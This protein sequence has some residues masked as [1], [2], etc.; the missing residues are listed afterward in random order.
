MKKINKYLKEQI[1]KLNKIVKKE[2][3]NVEINEEPFD[4]YLRIKVQYSPEDRQ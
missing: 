1:D 2:I 4:G 3:I